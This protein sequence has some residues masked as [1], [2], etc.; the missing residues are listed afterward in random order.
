MYCKNCGC[1]LIDG[2]RFCTNCGAPV[3]QGKNRK[4][5]LI[6]ISA[7]LVCS[8]IVGVLAWT[9]LSGDRA[10]EPKAAVGQEKESEKAQ[11]DEPAQVMTVDPDREALVEF[12]QFFMLYGEGSARDENFYF[13][14][15][16]T[17]PVTMMNSIM[18][19]ASCVDYA[20]YPGES[21]PEEHWGDAMDP[22]GWADTEYGTGSYYVYDAGKVDWIMRNIFNY[23]QEVISEGAVR[24]GRQGPAGP[25]ES[26]NRFY[27]EDGQYYYMTGGIGWE[28]V[29]DINIDR[30]EPEDDHYDIEYTVYESI[31]G[32]EQAPFS[33]S[34]KM[35]YKQI[36][37]M[38]YWS[39]LE[40]ERE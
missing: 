21:S 1:K 6:L 34:A 10:E 19:N 37:G 28:T 32:E 35:Q 15:T 12:L 8:G 29:Y 22:R 27:L 25:E 36:D 13:D 20:L 33:C 14:C 39:M 23:S 17:D 26:V 11:T 7:L 40:H 24:A 18:W 2:A 4:T 3:P 5:A 38:Y 31:M 16:S 9:L 30:L